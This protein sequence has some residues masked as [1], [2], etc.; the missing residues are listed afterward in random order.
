MEFSGI[1]PEFKKHYQGMFK[2]GSGVIERNVDLLVGERC[3]IKRMRWSRRGLG[4]MI[5]LREKRI[6]KEIS[7]PI[8]KASSF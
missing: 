8:L 4:N 1:N 3:K 5:F 6:N 2:R 7:S